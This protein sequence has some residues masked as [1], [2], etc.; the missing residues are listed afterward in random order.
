MIVKL[1]GIPGKVRVDSFLGPRFI[2]LSNYLF[3]CLFICSLY[4][5]YFHIYGIFGK[6]HVDN[7]LGPRLNMGIVVETVRNFRS[8][9]TTSL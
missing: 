3:I 9:N 8:K 1:H 7:F 2:Y 4:Y 6:V 5:T